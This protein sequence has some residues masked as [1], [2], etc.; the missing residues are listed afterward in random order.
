M[1]CQ[2]WLKQL[3]P[4]WLQKYQVVILGPFEDCYLLATIMPTSCEQEI[5]NKNK[6]ESHTL[7]CCL[8]WN[9]PFA[10]FT[11]WQVFLMWFI[12]KAILGFLGSSPDVWCPHIDMPEWL[13]RLVHS[14]SGTLLLTSCS[15]FSSRM[16][17]FLINKLYF[18]STRSRRSLTRSVKKSS[19]SDLWGN[20]FPWYCILWHMMW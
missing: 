17:C 2:S 20:F 18:L 1:F 14:S 4:P 13:S 5:K 16:L 3:L 12:S 6:S 10:L 9:V 19:K 15:F 8:C 11:P 7:K